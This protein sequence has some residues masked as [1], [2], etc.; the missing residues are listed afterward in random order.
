MRRSRRYGI[1]W[2]SCAPAG[3][4]SM[5]SSI[6]R[7][8]PRR[9]I[10]HRDSLTDARSCWLGLRT[11]SPWKSRKWWRRRLGRWR[12]AI[13]RRD[14]ETQRKRRAHATDH[15]RDGMG[16]ETW[17]ECRHEYRHGSLKGYATVRR[18]S[19]LRGGFRREERE[20]GGARKKKSPSF[21]RIDRLKPAPPYF[22]SKRA[23]RRIRSPLKTTSEIRSVAAIS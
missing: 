23:A 19:E 12:Q 17:E 7:H 9:R 2:S 16:W 3:N 15:V 8:R 20:P 11:S 5:E 13:Q 18:I 4:G 6:W 1:P 14:A 22:W 21:A 10:W